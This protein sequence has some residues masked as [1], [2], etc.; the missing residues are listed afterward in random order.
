MNEVQM[1]LV[2]ERRYGLLLMAYPA[3]YRRARG[4]EM[5]GTL[6]ESARPGQ[7]WP[8]VADSVDLLGGA[9]RR[10]LGLSTVPGLAA[11]LMLA[12]PL[13]LAF[14]GGI[15]GYYL[16][17]ELAAGPS[18]VLPGG[19]R[20][21]GPFP[22]IGPIVYI[23]WLA[24]AL[25]RVALPRLASRWLVGVGLAATVVVVPVAA[26]LG[27]TRPTLPLLVPLLLLGLIALAGS[28]HAA[29]R[30]E[31]F[32]L[33]VGTAATSGTLVALTYWH[34]AGITYIDWDGSQPDPGAL[35]GAYAGGLTLSVVGE[36]AFVLIIGLVFVGG[37]SLRRP[38]YDR[39][40]LWAAALLLVPGLPIVERLAL[41]LSVYNASTVMPAGLAA[42]GVVLAA[43]VRSARTDRR[44]PSAR[45]GKSMLQLA[46]VHALGSAVAVSAYAW[47]IAAS[48]IYGWG[49]G[50]D[51][52]VRLVWPL[53]ALASAVLPPRGTRA[54][55]MLAIAVTIALPADDD[56]H[57]YYGTPLH[58]VQGT[59]VALGVV[60]FAGLPSIR[61]RTTRAHLAGLAGATVLGILICAVP[62]VW[63]T[64]FIGTPSYAPLA[65]IVPCVVGLV[66]GWQALRLPLTM[67]WVRGAAVL[68]TSAG[69]LALTDEPYDPPWH[70]LAVLGV[71][72]CGLVIAAIWPRVAPRIQSRL[73]H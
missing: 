72:L 36:L 57:T 25:G 18:P 65:G 7:S 28:D 69:W 35:V 5:I 24:A 60:A 55:I 54:M 30:T 73:D 56:L 71:L 41:G 68:L 23:A 15:G 16:I 58:V 47:L 1:S 33:A 64:G 34:M 22:T 12:A 32:G 37:M 31:R 39:R 51:Q 20:G 14:A 38:P 42:G 59:L 17:A 10:R 46:G 61:P 9:L 3:E 45:S 62:S 67:R 43:A 48:G 11:G 52:F 70:T 4:A 8:S 13:A 40:A 53:A 19:Y 44:N 29:P 2:L 6:M 21:V 50:R 49:L 27:L 26:L 66:A 63:Q